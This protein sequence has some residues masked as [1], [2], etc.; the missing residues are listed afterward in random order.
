ML[1][2]YPVLRHLI[3]AVAIFLVLACLYVRIRLMWFVSGWP[4]LSPGELVTM[5]IISIPLAMAL[6]HVADRGKKN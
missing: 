4:F 5:A 6:L 2:Q 3:T 1:K